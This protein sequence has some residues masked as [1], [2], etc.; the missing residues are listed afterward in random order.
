M[1]DD[2]H[3]SAILFM[4]QR[5]G[6]HYLC[7]PDGDKLHLLTAKGGQLSEKANYRLTVIVFHVRRI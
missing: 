5:T 6:S 7:G 3:L 1:R 2:T 4:L